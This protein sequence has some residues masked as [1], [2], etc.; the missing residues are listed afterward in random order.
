MRIAVFTNFHDWNPGY[1]LTGIAT[2]QVEMLCRHGHDVHLYISEKHHESWDHMAPS[3]EGLTIHQS[4]PHEEL[5]DSASA[6]EDMTPEQ[7]LHCERLKPWL[8]EELKDADIAITH[9]WVFTGWNLP[10]ALALQ[11]IADQTRHVGFLHWL[12]SI[13]SGFRDWWNLRAYGAPDAQGNPDWPRNHFLIS[14]TESMAQNMADQF[15]CTR[16]HVRR[17]HHIKDPRSWFEFGEETRDFIDD[18]PGVLHADV[19]CVAPMA[20]D[21]LTAKNL[22]MAIMIMAGLKRRCLTTAFVC[23]NQWAS[24]QQYAEEL[25]QFYELADA[26]GLVHAKNKPTE[27][28]ADE[29]IFTSEWQ[30]PKYETGI[31]RRMLRELMLLSNLHLFPTMGESF[32]LVAPEAALCGAYLVLNRDLEVLQEIFCHEGAYFHFG[33]TYRGFEPQ[34]GW[35]RYLDSVSL[36][37]L[38]RMKRNEAV[39]TQ[40]F[41]RQRLNMDYLYFQQYEP[42]FQELRLMGVQQ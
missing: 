27:E 8:L 1:S 19:V 34:E 3:F 38:S 29:F 23:A 14:P 4:V 13:P 15:H 32:G 36:A 42:L 17:I 35:E 39:Q 33:S 5:H 41:T 6:D 18:F 20:C 7:A 30:Y 28:Y 25:D 37:V 2:D 11:Q 24:R 9:D 10:F 31:P 21:R 12:H 22:H 40:T 26:C 16:E